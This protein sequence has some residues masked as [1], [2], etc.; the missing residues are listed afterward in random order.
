MQ[1]VLFNAM[2]IIPPTAQIVEIKGAWPDIVSGKKA[3]TF[4]M[5]TAA[6]CILR[7]KCP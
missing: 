2:E 5:V 3:I 4:A 1:V 7:R 6:I